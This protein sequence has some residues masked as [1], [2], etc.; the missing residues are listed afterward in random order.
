MLQFATTD[1]TPSS[2]SGERFAARSGSPMALPFDTVGR[3][4]RPRPNSFIFSMSSFESETVVGSSMKRSGRVARTRW[5]RGVAFE[6]GGVK[7]SSTTSVSP[8]AAS[9]LPSTIGLTNATEAAVESMTKPMRS[10]LVPDAV[11]ASSMRIGSAS[12][13]C[14]TPVGEVWK[15]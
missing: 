12:S 5:I 11:S 13:A 7:V 8:C 2:S 6:S 3:R 4:P 15:M 10:G 14:F 9:A 1:I